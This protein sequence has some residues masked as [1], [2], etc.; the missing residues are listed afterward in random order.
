MKKSHRVSVRLSSE[1]WERLRL[2]AEIIGESLSSALRLC[3]KESRPV[4]FSTGDEEALREVSR[5]VAKIGGHTNQIARVLNSG[6]SRLSRDERAALAG[7][8]SRAADALA[9]IRIELAAIREREGARVE[10]AAKR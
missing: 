2:V 7:E 1:E 6:V 9:A 10:E 4:V 3:L 5:Q 8:L